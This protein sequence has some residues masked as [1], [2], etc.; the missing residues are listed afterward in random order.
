MRFGR[1]MGPRAPVA[2]RGTGARG[3]S[4]NHPQGN[5]EPAE[6]SEAGM[7]EFKVPGSSFWESSSSSSSSSS[8]KFNTE[9]DEDEDDYFNFSAQDRGYGSVGIGGCNSNTATTAKT[10]KRK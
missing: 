10:L 7:R 4:R 5:R 9:K 8:S 2:A 3:D 1:R 6:D